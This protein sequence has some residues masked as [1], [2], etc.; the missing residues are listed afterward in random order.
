MGRERW[1]LLLDYAMRQLKGLPQ[2][3]ALGGGTALRFLYN[4]RDS[5]DID[6]FFSDTQLRNY[7]TP[8]LNDAVDE[9]LDGYIEAEISTKLMF[10]EGEVDF[11]VA[12]P[13]T[14]IPPKLMCVA[15]YEI[16]IEDP[17]EIIAKKV[18]YRLGQIKARDIFDIL[19]VMKFG[20]DRFLANT[21]YFSAYA[22]EIRE[23]LGRVVESS[24][25]HDMEKYDVFPN[26]ELVLR[27][28][29]QL[30]Q[31]FLNAISKS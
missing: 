12:P 16:P 3:Y 2:R 11:I 17:I 14:A 5:N 18:R 30:Y 24:F 27:E 8:R 6:I 4:H 31:D 25:L 7:I 9:Y 19:T 21:E 26:G 13:A 15:G 1:E 20:R 23:R 22:D 29:R 10:A 28:H